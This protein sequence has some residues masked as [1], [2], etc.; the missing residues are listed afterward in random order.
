M[1]SV[2]Y[3]S[4]S[5]H[6]YISDF[7]DSLG[8]KQQSKIIRVINTIEE[9]GLSSANPHLR[10]IIYTPLWEIRILGEDNIRIIYAIISNNSI[11]LL[12]AFIKKDRKT[13]VKEINIALKRYYQALDK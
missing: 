2:K 1:T 7:L 11:I 6:Q 10:K 8:Y 12:H 3:Y 4:D 5:K 9:Y 13:P